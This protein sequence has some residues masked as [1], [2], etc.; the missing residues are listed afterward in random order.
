MVLL[1][2]SLGFS[3]H[4][5]YCP[6]K[7]CPPAMP[8]VAP[9]P[10]QPVTQTISV[11]V[12]VQQAPEV[13]VAPMC[14]PC[15]P[16]SVQ[17][18]PSKPYAAPVRVKLEVEPRPVG[19]VN[20]A[21]VAVRDPGPVKPIIAHSV[22]LAGSVVAL[23]FRSI[24]MFCATRQKK[25]CGPVPIYRP[26]APGPPPACGPITKC[27]PPRCAPPACAP[28]PVPVTCAP[29]GPSVAPLPRPSWY[30]PQP[31]PYI[32]PA[33]V[34][35]A[36]E[37]PATEPNGLLSGVYNLPSRILKRGRF[38]GDLAGPRNVCKPY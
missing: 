31:V 15:G 2:A 35:D 10:P 7:G 23:P 14:G 26:V 1:S 27:P 33:I 12:P 8:Q 25:Q 28:R 5:Q 17:I 38:Y 22:G 6:P 11:K 32:P 16:K 36:M 21:P 18:R 34:K 9:S 24:E 13:R 4:G 30:A 20:L 29:V 37:Y 3:F 19:N